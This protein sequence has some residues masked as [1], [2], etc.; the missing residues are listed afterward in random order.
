MKRQIIILAFLGIVIPFVAAKAEPRFR[1]PMNFSRSDPVSAYYDNNAGSGVT[2]WQCKG[3]TYNSHA[4]T[5]FR[6]PIGSYIS[7]GATGNLYYRYD[8]CPTWGSWGD[9]C[10]GRFGNHVR[11]AHTS[12]WDESSSWRS[13]YAHLSQ[14][15]ANVRWYSSVQC[16]A[17]VGNSGSSGSS[18]GPH[19][20]FEVRRYGYPKDDPYAGACS[21][22][23]SFWVNQN[24]G[25]PT[26]QCQ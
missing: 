18:T 4:G 12:P 24:G 9:T 20:H 11:I 23:I 10:G 17:W 22:P 2:D 14:G 19:M 8:A 25:N 3:N 7:A 16:G 15:T 13:Y 21:G 5:D 1:N 6:A 26:P